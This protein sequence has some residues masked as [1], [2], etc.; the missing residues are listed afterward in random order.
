M[1][2]VIESEFEL[3]SLKDLIGRTVECSF[4]NSLEEFIEEVQKEEFF[5]SALEMYVVDKG[6]LYK[7]AV[8]ERTSYEVDFEEVA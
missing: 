6:K 2:A 8:G 5:P 4:F 1:I 3:Y 7:V